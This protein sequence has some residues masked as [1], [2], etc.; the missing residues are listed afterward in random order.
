MNILISYADEKYRKAQVLNTWTGKHIARF[1]KIY[2]FGPNDVDSEYR[3]NHKEI[4][5]IQRGNGLWLWKPYF[6]NKVLNG[7]NDG[8]IVFYCDSGAIFTRGIEPIINILEKEFIFVVDCPLLEVNF[9]KSE[10]FKKMDC[11]NEKIVFSNQILATYLAIRCCPESRALVGE[12]LKWCEDYEMLAPR[13]NP[14]VETD[15]PLQFISHR[16]DQ[17]ILS[18]LC[19]KNGITPHKDISQRG[20]QPYTYYNSLYAFDAPS[21]EDEY[22]PILFLH[23]C[24]ELKIINLIK[25]YILCKRQKRMYERVKK[26]SG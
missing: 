19:K 12:W 3:K 17:S 24:P 9:T 13:D 16:E 23:K 1:D 18:L 26:A 11:E 21:H 6:I 5:A 7:A 10:C 25:Y 8:D 2:E 15:S 14:H 4:F 20:E 22:R